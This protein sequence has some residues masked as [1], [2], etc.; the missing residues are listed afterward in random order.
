MRDFPPP[1][2]RNV[3]AVRGDGRPRTSSGP[4]R[5]AG[6]ARVHRPSSGTGQRH[7]ADRRWRPSPRARHQRPLDRSRHRRCHHAGAPTASRRPHVADRSREAGA[8]SLARRPQCDSTH[9]RRRVGAWLRRSG[10]ARL[11]GRSSD[12]VVLRDVRRIAHARLRRQNGRELVLLLAGGSR[13]RQSVGR[14]AER[15]RRRAA[16]RPNARRVRRRVSRR[17]R[18]RVGVCRAPRV[19]PPD[20]PPAPSARARAADSPL[21]CIWQQRLVLGVR[22][23]H[24]RHRAHGRRAHR[25][26]VSDGRESAVRRDRRRVATRP[27]RGQV[28]HRHLGSRQRKVRRHGG[29]RRRRSTRGRSAGHLDSPTASAGERARFVAPGARP[30]DARPNGS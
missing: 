18:R 5:V 2:P 9:P 8:P 7:G 17:P 14:R 24:R 13:R 16:R 27:R 21:A 28:G 15:R 23:E 6:A 29:A 3:G 1:V 22:K 25:R 30:R 11:G 20:V 12:A 4:R 10:M 26:I 19:L